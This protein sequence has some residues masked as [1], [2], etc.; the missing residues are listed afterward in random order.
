M[1]RPGRKGASLRSA[2]WC[3]LD[4]VAGRVPGHHQPGHPALRGQPG[5]APGDGHARRIQP[6]RHRLQGGGIGDFPAEAAGAIALARRHHQP[7]P[8]VIHAEDQLRG[9]AFGQLQA[10]QAGAE[11]GPVLRAFRLDA[12]IA[13]GLDRHAAA[14]CPHASSGGQCTSVIS[15]IDSLAVQNRPMLS[16]CAARAAASA[17]ASGRGSWSKWP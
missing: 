15:G 16:A 8:A 17:S 13:K 14:P 6:R 2:P 1:Q 7:L 10:K 5:I 12:D 11:A 3:D 4:A 9:A